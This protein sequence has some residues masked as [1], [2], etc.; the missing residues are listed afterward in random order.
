[1]NKK[2][3]VAIITGGAK[4]VGA[5]ICRRLQKSNIDIKIHYKKK[6]PSILENSDDIRAMTLKEYEIYI[7]AHIKKSEYPSL[8]K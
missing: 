4:K 8:S 2:K 6:L 3:Q 5:A 7:D 1:M